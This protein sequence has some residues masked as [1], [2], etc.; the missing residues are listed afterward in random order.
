MEWIFEKRYRLIL[1][2]FYILFFFFLGSE[3]PISAVYASASDDTGQPLI[4]G[5]VVHHA[6]ED[7]SSIEAIDDDIDDEYEVANEEIVEQPQTNAVKD[8]S[9]DS[10]TITLNMTNAPKQA[11]CESQL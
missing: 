5:D 7:S 8:D 11:T 6:I 2:P 4:L 10:L 3:Q 1:M 9:F